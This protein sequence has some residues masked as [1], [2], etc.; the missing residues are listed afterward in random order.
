M[1]RLSTTLVAAVLIVCSAACNKE[2]PPF[3]VAHYDRTAGPSK[4]PLAVDPALVGSYPASTKSGAGYFYDDVLEYRVWLHPERGARRLAGEHDYFAAFA[5]YEAALE[6]SRQ[7]Q[8]AEDPLV[9]VRQQEY[10]NE[11]SP[12]TF[13][14]EK[15]ERVTEWRVKWLTG[16]HRGANSIPE[17]L[18]A[19]GSAA[20]Q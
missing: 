3:S 10:I 16:S 4:H 13:L 1:R 17:F 20:T 2:L 7:N 9:L 14:W 11:P 15:S 6:F 8:G 19:H 12:G 18:A 5:R